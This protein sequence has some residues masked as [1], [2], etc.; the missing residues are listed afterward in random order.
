MS[1]ALS[2]SFPVTSSKTATP[3]KPSGWVASAHFRYSA[4]PF[5]R[6]GMMSMRMS[7]K[8]SRC[9]CRFSSQDLPTGE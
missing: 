3:S 8:R 2:I 1:L 9:L 6:T 4:S 5:S 7:K